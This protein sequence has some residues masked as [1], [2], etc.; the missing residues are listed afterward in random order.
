MLL[1][2]ILSE[3][4]RG[5]RPTQY[6]NSIRCVGGFL[7]P[8]NFVLFS[9]YMLSYYHQMEGKLNILNVLK[10]LVFLTPITNC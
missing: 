3:H 6:F 2:I 4:T 10:A 1:E 7:N 5:S 9:F 8:H